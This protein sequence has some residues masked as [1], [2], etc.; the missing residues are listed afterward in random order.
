MKKK[1]SL[2]QKDELVPFKMALNTLC[3]VLL[4]LTVFLPYWLKIQNSQ[5]HFHMGIWKSCENKIFLLKAVQ[6]LMGSAI[7]TGILALV[8]IFLLLISA[9]N[10]RTFFFLSSALCSFVT[11]LLGLFGQSIFMVITN[12]STLANIDFLYFDWAFYLG[13]C[14]YVLYLLNGSLILVRKHS[15]RVKPARQSTDKSMQECKSMST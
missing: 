9:V 12:T 8:N 3:L 2:S 11:A 7:L 15:T 4:L 6:A 10:D 5:E 14:T 13:W 1:H